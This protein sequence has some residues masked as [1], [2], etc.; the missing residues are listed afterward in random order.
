[1][2]NAVYTQ[3]NARVL[4]VDDD[5]PARQLVR[6]YLGSRGA[7]VFEAENSYFALGRL[8][9]AEIDLVITDINMPGRSGLWLIEEI[10]TRWPG[11]PVIV[12]TAEDSAQRAF[13][14]L[15]PNVT[16]LTKPYSLHDLGKAVD[17]VLQQTP[18]IETSID[19]TERQHRLSGPYTSP[20]LHNVVP[21]PDADNEKQ[22]PWLKRVHP[23]DADRVL[24]KVEQCVDTGDP[25][26][27]EYRLFSQR[28]DIFWVLHEARVA[29]H[30]NRR[31]LL[32]HEAVIDITRQR[33]EAEDLRASEERHR[34]LTEYSSDMI[35]VASWEGR[36]LYV[37]PASA[38]LLGFE[39]V[40]LIGTTFYDMVH[41]GDRAAVRR[42]H[43]GVLEKAGAALIAYRVQRKDGRYI[44]FESAIREVPRSGRDTPREL[45]V[46]SRDITDRKL[47]EERLKDMA[48]LDDLTGLY[49]RRGFMA[50]ATQ[51]LKQAKRAKRQALVIFADLNGL[52]RINDTHGHADGD[53]AII[54]AA[55]V[56]NRTFRDSDVVARV[57]GDEFAIL[58]IEADD[59][60]VEA[61]KARLQ[62]ALDSANRGNRA[63]ELSVSIGIVPFDPERDASVEE[64][65]ATADREMYVHKNAMYQSRDLLN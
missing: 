15:L 16:V 30:Q 53:R 49:N 61:I 60:S 22:I 47:Q 64:L 28:G 9:E 6:K 57:G 5:A 10:R 8:T 14:D 20:T 54:A 18:E 38:A 1:M 46:V 42:T 36:Y 43:L 35:S 52:K 34:F 3:L 12:T 24:A 40:Q 29:N 11:L 27:C 48:I 32:A 21:G 41:E 26:I 4:V 63:Y 33:R 65:M 37:S 51:H 45:V 55:E 44:W 2:S 50:L 13:R 39:P 58:A 23:D 56:F 59:Q 62:A 7:T 31:R 17:E 25:F 19:E